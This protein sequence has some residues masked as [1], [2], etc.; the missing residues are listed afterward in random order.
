MLTIYLAGISCQPRKS[1]MGRP[2]QKDQR[3]GEILDAFERCLPR[4]GLEGST[5]ERVAEEAGVQRTIIR[6]YIGNRA[7]LLVALVSRYLEQSRRSLDVFIAE[8]PKTQ[9]AATAVRWLFDPQYSDPQSVRVA[10]ALTQ[11]SSEQPW[12]AE[13]MRAWLDDFV[14][15]LRGIIA[16]DYPDASPEAVSAAAAGI[17]GIY[18][19][20]EASYALGDV[21]ALSK[22]SKHAAMMLLDAVERER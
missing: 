3:T 5:L 13:K 16:D 14:A 4:Y 20:V 7:E 11:A 2:S 15:R 19:N 10:S 9:R 12:L 22:A 17:A 8:L 6:H 1:I 18:F 21:R